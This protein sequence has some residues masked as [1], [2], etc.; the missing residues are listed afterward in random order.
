MKKLFAVLFLASIT[1]L[2][3]SKIGEDQSS[4]SGFTIENPNQVVNEG[5]VLLLKTSVNDATSY[6]WDFGNGNTSTLKDPGYA[7]PKCG[8]YKIS[9]MVT[10]ANNVI[11]TTTKDITVLCIFKSPNHAPVF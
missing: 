9:L 7:Y 5:S 6:Y 3:C 10:D 11:S 2:N 8:N 4:P 1:L